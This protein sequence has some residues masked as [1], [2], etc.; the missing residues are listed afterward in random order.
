MTPYRQRATQINALQWKGDNADELIAFAGSR[1]VAL[2]PEDRTDDPDA[3]AS[4]MESSH[5]S[6]ELLYT[7]DWVIAAADS[8]TSMPDAAFHSRY[9]AAPVDAYPPELTFRIETHDA[10]TWLPTGYP[11]P[12]LEEARIVRENRRARTQQLFRIIEQTE[13]SRVVESDEVPAG[14][15]VVQA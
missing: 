13:T 2:D 14:A 7:G 3:T 5:N 8:F 15:E 12:T 10:G 4:L 6:W 9:E 11:R 1:F